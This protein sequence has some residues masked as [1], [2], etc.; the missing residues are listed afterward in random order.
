MFPDQ[1][2]PQNL[3]AAAARLNQTRAA[4]EARS[5][6]PP[7]ANSVVAGVSGLT[8]VELNGLRDGTT[9]EFRTRVTTAQGIDA[10]F[11]ALCDALF[12]AFCLVGGNEHWLFPKPLFFWC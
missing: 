10:L 2:P 8:T 3:S 5:R 1:A 12:G 4:K 7:H 11:D 9:Y 6:L